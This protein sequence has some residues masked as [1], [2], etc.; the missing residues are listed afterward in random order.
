MFGVGHDHPARVDD[1]GGDEDQ[2]TPVRRNR[3]AVRGE[4]DRVR[5]A[6]RAQDVGGD[7]LAVPAGHRLQHARR[8]RHFP[9]QVQLARA[10]VGVC[11]MLQ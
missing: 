7:H 10:A 4:A 6:G 1:L 11:S 3:L 2:R 9:G 5:G 8:V